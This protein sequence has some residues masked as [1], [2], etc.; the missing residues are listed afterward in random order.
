MLPDHGAWYEVLRTLQ[1]G[2]F[3]WHRERLREERAL[4]SCSQLQA[5]GREK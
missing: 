3:S 5:E 4:G 2:V 1:P